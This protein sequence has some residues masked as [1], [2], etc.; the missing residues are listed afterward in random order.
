[1]G[2]GLGSVEWMD[3][4]EGVRRELNW[5]RQGGGGGG[6]VRRTMILD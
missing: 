3:N 2:K 1:M 6:R 4:E 5:E